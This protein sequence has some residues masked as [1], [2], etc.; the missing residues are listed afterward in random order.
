M[1]KMTKEE[2]KAINPHRD[3]IQLVD[4]VLMGK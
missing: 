3:P 1:I 4:E 2:I